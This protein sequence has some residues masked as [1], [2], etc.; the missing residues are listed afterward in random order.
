MPALLVDIWGNDLYMEKRIDGVCFRLNIDAH[1]KTRAWK[2]KKEA[3]EGVYTA[4]KRAVF[5]DG[6]RS[7]DPLK[8]PSLSLS[9]FTSF[10][11]LSIQSR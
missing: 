8:L 9:L 1:T 4:D 5:R 11:P 2:G 3:D 6:G 10:F 7:L